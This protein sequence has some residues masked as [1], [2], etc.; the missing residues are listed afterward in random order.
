MSDLIADLEHS[1]S[2]YF[3]DNL[4]ARIEAL[5]QLDFFNTPHAEAIR[6][7]LEAANSTVYEKIRRDIRQGRGEEALAHWVPPAEIC[8][9]EKYDYRDEVI[10]GVFQFEE[11]P[12][13][14]LQRNPE[15]VAYQPTPVR[16][17][18]DL[19]HRTSLTQHDV[20]IDL[21]SGLGHVALLTSICTRARAM[22]IELEP[23][24]VRIARQTAESLKLKSVTF[25]ERDARSADLTEGTVFY[26]YTPFKGTILGN[27]LD[28]L[29]REAAHRKIRICTYG[30]CTMT[31]AN[32][33]WLEPLDTPQPDRISI[34]R[35]HSP[36]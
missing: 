27:V 24:Y 29:R 20:L 26:L 10:A 16:H 8:A 6:T 3:P 23:A 9:G 13:Q 5:E 19:F 7:R 14:I 33:P 25:I 11:P 1:P 12:A 31:I 35:S 15:M 28:S 18:F 4:R 21:G 34:F 32:E 17:I 22:G 36:G 30:P 2:L